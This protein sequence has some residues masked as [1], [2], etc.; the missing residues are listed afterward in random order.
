MPAQVA[1]GGARTD[2]LAIGAL[3]F[4]IL[5]LV[6][7]VG[8]LGVLLGPAAAITGFISRQRVTA[9]G[10]TLGGGGYALAGMILGIVGFV[11]SVLAFFF[12]SYSFT[13]SSINTLPLTSP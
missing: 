11:A 4:G 5:S 6:C 3:I 7:S 9:S 12:W 1:Y 13:H 2:G 8:C 10:G